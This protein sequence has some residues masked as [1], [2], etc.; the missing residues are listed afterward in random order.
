MMDY[1]FFFSRPLSVK[2]IEIADKSA[3]EEWIT[4]GLDCFG[5]GWE[6]EGE[7]LNNARWNFCPGR[8]LVTWPVCV[9]VGLT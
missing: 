9:P 6:K 7:G 3:D 4:E 8:G 2:E 1:F 5:G